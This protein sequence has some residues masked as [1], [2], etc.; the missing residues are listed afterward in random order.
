MDR[1]KARSVNFDQLC[2]L[3]DRINFYGVGAPVWEGGGELWEILITDTP[4]F[5]REG[6][7]QG[8][9]MSKRK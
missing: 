7:R 4:L 9:S 1:A 6:L 8:P 3:G 2:V 5:D